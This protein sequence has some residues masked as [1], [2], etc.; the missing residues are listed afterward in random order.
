MK[1]KTTKEIVIINILFLIPLLI[2][3]L[4]KNGY[5]LY[6]K[7]LVN[8]IMLF[9]PLYLTLISIVIKFLFDLIIDHKISIN[10]NL[11]VMILVS[12]IMPYNINILLYTITLSITYFLTTLLENKIKFNKVCLIYLIIILIN[13]FANG[14]NFM[15]PLESKYTFSFSFLDLLIGRSIGGI[16]ST[17]IFFSLLA[18]TLLFNS[19][20]YKKDIPFSIN[21]TYLFFAFIY[22]LI[23]NNNLLLNSEIIFASIFIAPLPKYSPYKIKG[24]IISGI[25]IGIIT[26]ILSLLIN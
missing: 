8:M 3:G 6:E 20:Y 2:Y 15:S 22:L 26:F 9:K 17:S 11:L 14:L 1:K 25:L 21:L 12:M 18:Y 16:S 13:F 4:F 10:Y 19:Y 7:N 5:L 24:Q 23:T